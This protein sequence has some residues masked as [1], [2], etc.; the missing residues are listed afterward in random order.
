[1][2]WALQTR[3]QWH[4]K[5][6]AQRPW[7]DLELP[8]HSNALAL[9]ATAVTTEVGNGNTTL[10]WTDCWILGHSIEI[11]APLVFSQVSP[12][13]PE[14]EICVLWLKLCTTILVTD[15]QGGLSWLGII[16]FLQLWDRIRE[17]TLNDQEDRHIW[18]LEASGSYSSKSAYRAFSWIQ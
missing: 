6:R 5:T 18:Q 14:L 3:W 15:M 1:M 17:C 8:S 10:F 7:N 12:R 16:E 2:A 11:I 9:F 4:K 13:V